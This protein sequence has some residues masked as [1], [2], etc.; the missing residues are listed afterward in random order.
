MGLGFS[1]LPKQKPQLSLGDI[2]LRELWETA[3]RNFL[4]ASFCESYS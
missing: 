3:F 2:V 4:E 1:P